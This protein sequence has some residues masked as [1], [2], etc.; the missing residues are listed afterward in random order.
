MDSHALNLLEQIMIC[1]YGLYYGLSHT[2]PR[3]DPR[4]SLCD[5]SN[6]RHVLHTD[7]HTPDPL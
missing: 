4:Q 1:Y 7:A 2:T 3:V 5:G 6:L